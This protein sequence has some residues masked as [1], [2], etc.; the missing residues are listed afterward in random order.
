M[1]AIESEEATY[2]L[3]ALQSKLKEV[4][5]DCMRHAI[6]ADTESN[7]RRKVEQKN[8]DLNAKYADARQGL[9]DT[10]AALQNLHEAHEQSVQ[11]RDQR[12]AQFQ[13]MVSENK[14]YET[15]ID[16]LESRLRVAESSTKATKFGSDAITD[17][18]KEQLAKEQEKVFKLQSECVRVRGEK[19]L[20]DAEVEAQR[21]KISSLELLHK[22]AESSLHMEYD[23]EI[24]RLRDVNKQ[25]SERVEDAKINQRVLD[26]MQLDQKGRIAQFKALEHKLEDLDTSRRD[27]ENRNSLLEIQ[28]RGCEATIRQM[29]AKARQQEQELSSLTAEISGLK[30]AA[31]QAEELLKETAFKAHNMEVENGRLSSEM[32]T[33]AQKVNTFPKMVEK[34]RK[35]VIPFFL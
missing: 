27:L 13:R 33:N 3:N 9:R 4:Q 10:Q 14:M 18:L 22:K 6:R 29:D 15:R 8:S 16:E 35:R 17:Q 23:V 19:T 7:E 26:D 12:E 31:V 1:Q 28:L 25:L 32:E 11:K 34:V 2:V 24:E 20:L 5:S 21:R 30:R